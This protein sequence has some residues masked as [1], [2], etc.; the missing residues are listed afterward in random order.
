MTLGWLNDNSLKDGP[1]QFVP[2]LLEGDCR[3]FLEICNGCILDKVVIFFGSN[4]GL[5]VEVS[6]SRRWASQGFADCH[7]KLRK[8][9]RTSG[10]RPDERAVRRGLGDLSFWFVTRCFFRLTYDG[11]GSTLLVTSGR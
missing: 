6:L 5:L 11:E 10:V 3:I 9:C 7:R 1:F 8:S 4:P 2:S